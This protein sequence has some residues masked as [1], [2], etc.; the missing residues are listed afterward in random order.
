MDLDEEKKI[1]VHN[2]HPRVKAKG[3]IKKLWVKKIGESVLEVAG[4][5]HA[6]K[7]AGYLTKY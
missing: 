3:V 1:S 5:D 6:Q 2:Q 7:E 4:Q